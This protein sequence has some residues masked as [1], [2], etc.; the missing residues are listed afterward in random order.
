MGLTPPRGEVTA[1]I[2]TVSMPENLDFAT[3]VVNGAGEYEYEGVSIMGFP[4]EQSD[5]LQT[6][7]KIEMEGI[8]IGILGKLLDGL[9]PKTLEELEEVDILIAPAGGPPLAAVPGVARLIKQIEPKIVIPSL[10]KVAGLKEKRGDVAAF[11]KEMGVK[12]AAP[13]EKLVLKKKDFETITGT[14]V[15]VLSI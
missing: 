11:W 10:Y 14:V 13:E 4:V 2:K 8:T 1:T 12:S 3:N 9:P 15:K 7:Y 6:V 5:V